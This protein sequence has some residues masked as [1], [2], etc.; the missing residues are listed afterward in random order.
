M[1]P[2]DT[3]ASRSFRSS[4][5]SVRLFPFDRAYVDQGLFA[6]LRQQNSPFCKLSS[7][8]ATDRSAVVGP[9]AS[10][11]FGAGVAAEF[12]GPSSR[13]S[14]HWGTGERCAG[15]VGTPR[16]VAVRGLLR[17]HGGGQRLKRPILQRMST[18]FVGYIRAYSIVSAAISI[19]E[20]FFFLD[21]HPD[22][23]TPRLSRR[24]IHDP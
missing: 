23:S 1:I 18:K 22:F 19:F 4:S 6:D 15:P 8:A 16:S 20:S 12:E 21:A 14:D 3:T 11:D 7:I 10:V 13:S 5:G 17:G 9:Y 2:G 24:P